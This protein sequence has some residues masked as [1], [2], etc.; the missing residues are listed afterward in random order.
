MDRP[1]VKNIKR[2]EADMGEDDNI[3]DAEFQHKLVDDLSR[4]KDTYTKGG[5]GNL[6]ITTRSLSIVFQE[7]S[8]LHRGRSR[9]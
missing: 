4:L 2:L 5:T 7:H 8:S 1:V 3:Y 6:L 9:R